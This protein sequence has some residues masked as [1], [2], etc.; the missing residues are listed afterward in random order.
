MNRDDRDERERHDEHHA[1]EAPRESGLG[2]PDIL[3]GRDDG[4]GVSLERDDLTWHRRLTRPPRE[5][6]AGQRRHEQYA[7][8]KRDENHDGVHLVQELIFEP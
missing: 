5:N 1:K 6:R 8:G 3:D 7:D 2:S 4:H